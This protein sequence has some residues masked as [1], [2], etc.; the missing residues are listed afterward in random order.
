MT[1]YIVYNIQTHNELCTF[2]GAAKNDENALQTTLYQMWYTTNN[3]LVY[4]IWELALSNIGINIVGVYG[5]WH[6]VTLVYSL[7]INEDCTA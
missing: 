7:L 4:C 2:T 5:P 3:L 6:W 1:K